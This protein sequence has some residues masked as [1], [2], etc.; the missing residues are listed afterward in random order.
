MGFLVAFSVYLVRD[1]FGVTYQ[2]ASGQVTD[3][4]QALRNAFDSVAVAEQ[5]G[6]NVSALL[7]RLNGA[8]T[9]L[10]WAEV[11]LA[12]GNYSDAASF[13]GACRSEAL[14]IDADAVMLGNDAI[15][16]GGN[17]WMMAVFSFAG[18]VAYVVV[19]FFV[20]RWFKRGHL[21]RV[22]QSRPEVTG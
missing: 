17:R 22:M 20:W 3:A 7:S 11:T 4:D 2:E 15:L 18:S 6:A 1:A 10:T 8:G 12:A 19:L 13:A 21:K 14:S 9:N 16:A 5:Q